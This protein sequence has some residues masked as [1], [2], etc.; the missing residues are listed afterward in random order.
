[1]DCNDFLSRYSDYDDSL[2]SPADLSDFRLHMSRCEPCARYDRVLRK[3]RMVARQI[4][5]LRPEEP[6]GPRLNQ[7]LW[8]IRTR[9][10]RAALATP[11]GLAGALAGVTVVLV[12]LWTVTLLDQETAAGAL[13]EAGPVVELV[14]QRA[15]VVSHASQQRRVL[16]VDQRNAPREWNARRVDH[17]AAVS[18]SPLV[19]GP[20]SYR[21]PGA[22]PATAIT[23][24]FSLD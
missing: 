19:T 5:A 1:M 2:L 15:V 20:P 24:G 16:P 22:I 18:Y 13:A 7:R 4:P 14:P 21:A 17:H 23:T 9:R 6:M 3:G 11:G 12:G 10:R 8:Q